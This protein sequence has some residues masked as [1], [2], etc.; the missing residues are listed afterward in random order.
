VV[1]LTTQQI[2]RQDSVDNAIFELLQQLCPQSETMKWDIEAIGSIRDAMR[3]QVV[4]RQ[5]SL[6]EAQFYPYLRI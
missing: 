1:E 5:R 6:S 4:D 2:E 3:E